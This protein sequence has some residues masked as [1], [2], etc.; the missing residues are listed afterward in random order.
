MKRTLIPLLLAI[1]LVTLC[2]NASAQVTR[3]KSL[4]AQQTQ[5]FIED[6]VVAW[7]Y[8]CFYICDGIKIPVTKKQD[9]F[10]HT[11]DGAKIPDTKV[12]CI[13]TPVD[14][15]ATANSTANRAE[16]KA[17]KA[18]AGNVRAQATADS[19]LTI[20]L[21]ALACCQNNDQLDSLEQIAQLLMDGQVQA[22][23]ELDILTNE[24]PE[25]QSEA[26]Q[27]LQGKVS[28]LEDKDQMFE[29]YVQSRGKHTWERIVA[30]AQEAKEAE[31]HQRRSSR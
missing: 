23:A 13:G 24:M 20:A 10:Y 21:Q 31:K 18:L 9:G 2:M 22:F 27:E 29:A 30:R 28:D 26:V 11:A 17:D 19:A 16:R 8:K 25:D 4:N 1:F 12:T 7:N 15:V 6:A 14:K 5:T 3:E